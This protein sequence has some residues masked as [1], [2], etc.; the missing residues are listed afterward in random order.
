MIA[1]YSDTFCF[2]VSQTLKSTW[3]IYQVV[4]KVGIWELTLMHNKWLGIFQKKKKKIDNWRILLLQSN[5]DSFSALTIT[6]CCVSQITE[7][8]IFEPPLLD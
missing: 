2:N 8:A 7:L 6:P 3:A 1:Y 4:L 5:W